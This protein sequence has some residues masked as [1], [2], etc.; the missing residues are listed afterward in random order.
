MCLAIALDIVPSSACGGVGSD[1]RL[2]N[3]GLCPRGVATTSDLSIVSSTDPREDR[4]DIPCTS[5]RFFKTAGGSIPRLC[6]CAIPSSWVWSAMDFPVASRCPSHPPLPSMSSCVFCCWPPSPVRFPSIPCPR[7]EIMR[8]DLDGKGR[9]DRVQLRVPLVSPSLDDEAAMAATTAHVFGA[10]VPHTRAFGGKKRH[11]KTRAT[12]LELVSPEDVREVRG[13]TRPPVLLALPG[14]DVEQL[15]A[16]PLIEAVQKKCVHP[17]NRWM[18]EPAMRNAS[19]R[20]CKG[21]TCA[22]TCVRRSWT[23]TWRCN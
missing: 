16:F 19:R 3:V 1:G 23:R 5:P 2:W 6:A 10:A 21:W 9:S 12:S 14:G 11:A 15:L 17:S 18:K 20:R 8:Q 4:M 22:R 13:A 7:I